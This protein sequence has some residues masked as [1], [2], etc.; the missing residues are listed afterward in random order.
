MNNKR[1][2][3]KK[4]RKNESKVGFGAVGEKKEMINKIINE[5]KNLER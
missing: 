4:L 5:V 2:E 3:G 1:R